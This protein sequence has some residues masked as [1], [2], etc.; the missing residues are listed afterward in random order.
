M[1]KL[2]GFTLFIAIS[3][4]LLPLGVL[5]S[6][7][8]AVAASATA[9][10]PE[11][12]KVTA[13][14]SF[15]VLH[16][17]QVL[18]LT[19]EEYIFGVVAAEMP[20]LYHEEALKAQAVAAYTFACCKREQNRDLDYDITSDHTIDQ[21]FITKQEAADKWG[22]SAAEYTKKIENAIKETRGQFITYNGVPISALYHA[23]S[24]GKTEDPKNVWGGE[25]PYLKPVSSEG[26][27]LSADF[28]STSSFTAEELREKLGKLAVLE[29]EPKNYFGK[30]VRTDSGTVTEI[31]VCKKAL[32]GFELQKALGLKS[33]S[34]EVSFADN[35]FTFTV[36]G[37]G[38][39]VGMSQNG[40]N[41]MAKQGA[42]YK[43]I[44]KHYYTGCE[45]K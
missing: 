33:A 19:A 8:K 18:E 15:K 43:E 42:G 27:K 38:H 25:R 20:A 26:D 16:N 41:F 45:I 12:E 1:K 22:D 40:A 44:L 14:E 3:M 24:P 11:N 30:S 7:E 17:S 13:A 6:P 9:L 39:G 37:S 2:F 21:S 4:L 23:I 28:I 5:K 10:L 29:G 36:Y 35:S 31:T 34:F 32:T